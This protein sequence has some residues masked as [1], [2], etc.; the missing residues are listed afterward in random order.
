[1]RRYKISLPVI[2]A[3]LLSLASPS[4]RVNGLQIHNHDGARFS[5]RERNK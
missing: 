4:G 5:V 2:A 1:M 3:L